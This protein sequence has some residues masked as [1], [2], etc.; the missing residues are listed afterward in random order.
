MST[1]SPTEPVVEPAG[2]AQEPGEAPGLLRRALTLVAPLAGLAIVLV[3]A[4]VTT[5]GFYSED[6]LRLVLF[7]AGFIGVTAVGQTLV[8]LVGGIDLSIGAVVGLTTVIVATYTAGDDARLGTAVLLALLAGLGI[9][10]LNGALVV[11]R[12][13]PATGPP[14]MSVPLRDFR[15]VSRTVPLTPTSTRQCRRET[16]GSSR[17]SWHVEARPIMNSP[18]VRSRSWCR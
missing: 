13:V 2:P 6:V 1:A 9:G 18:A 5:P 16:S 8:L 17:E 7:Q 11:R 10:I 12:Q 15:S 14:L 4:A 3:L